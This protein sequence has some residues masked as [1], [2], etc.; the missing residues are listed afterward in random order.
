MTSSNDDASSSSEESAVAAQQDDYDIVAADEDK[1]IIA[2]KQHTKRQK[3]ED[4]PLIVLRE[5][6]RELT[7]PPHAT[8]YHTRKHASNPAPSNEVAS[9]TTPFPAPRA[10]PRPAGALR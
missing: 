2:S 8:G 5:N 3:R 9:A 4:T 10:L 7:P 1:P 6:M